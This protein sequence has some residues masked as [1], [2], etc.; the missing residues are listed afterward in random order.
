M[1]TNLS[2]DERPIVAFSTSLHGT[3][4]QGV[5]RRRPWKDARPSGDRMYQNCAGSRSSTG[6]RARLLQA[7]P[8]ASQSTPSRKGLVS[9]PPSFC[10]SPAAVL[11]HDPW[12]SRFP[13]CTSAPT[14][15]T[16]GQGYGSSADAASV[17][18]VLG[19]RSAMDCP[20]T[21]HDACERSR[22]SL[23]YTARAARESNI[24]VAIGALCRL[25]TSTLLTERY[26]LSTR[27][28]GALAT[29]A[30]GT[31]LALHRGTVASLGNSSEERRICR[32]TPRRAG[33]LV[34]GVTYA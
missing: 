15:G 3:P 16:A 14:Y 4:I 5:S 33:A 30:V 6:L 20:T 17:A 10:G 13:E 27:L 22:K 18:T 1:G 12:L 2:R 26:R 9:P 19:A 31:R 29:A 8:T 7:P 24:A 28:L 11:T 34:P 21:G 23:Q 25:M 32:R